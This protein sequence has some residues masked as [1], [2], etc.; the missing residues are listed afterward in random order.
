M[1]GLA[2]L[3][4]AG[5]APAV[6]RAFAAQPARLADLVEE[7]GGCGQELQAGVAGHVA[8][9]PAVVAA[10]GLGE[11]FLEEGAL[12]GEEGGDGA[13]AEPGEGSDGNEGVELR[14]GGAEGDYGG[15]GEVGG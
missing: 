4:A 9:W 14:V 8:G 12:G 13:A 10:V 6:T 2:L 3:E 5:L 15:V 1:P 7:E 11:P